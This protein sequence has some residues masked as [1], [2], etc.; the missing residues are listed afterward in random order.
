MAT[1]KS[2]EQKLATHAPYMNVKR[3]KNGF[4]ITIN[5]F[6][7]LLPERCAFLGF[8]LSELSDEKVDDAIDSIIPVVAEVKKKH[9]EVSVTKTASLEYLAKAYEAKDWDEIA[10]TANELSL[11]DK[12]LAILDEALKFAKS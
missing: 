3:N 6:P 7:F 5:E 9:S 12:Q 8:K 4:F 11:I 2:I 1:T 10:S